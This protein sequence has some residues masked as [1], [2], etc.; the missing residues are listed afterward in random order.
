MRKA[1]LILAAL[2]IGCEAPVAPAHH[3][4]GYIVA[5][6]RDTVTT[7]AQVDSVRAAVSAPAD[8]LSLIF[9][10]DPTKPGAG[11]YTLGGVAYKIAGTDPAYSCD[12]CYPLLPGTR[13]VLWDGKNTF[14][15]PVLDAAHIAD[16]FKWVNTYHAPDKP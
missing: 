12:S 14:F 5:Y 13:V 3:D 11:Y 4:S 8:S 6:S 2:V 16:F 9:A 7:Q 15:G 10:A 1:L